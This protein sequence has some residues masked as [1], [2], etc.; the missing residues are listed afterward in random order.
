MDSL[1]FNL[2]LNLTRSHAT[3]HMTCERVSSRFPW[4]DCL[5]VYL[6]TVNNTVEVNSNG[7]GEN[8]TTVLLSVRVP[9][10]H[11]YQ[12]KEN[13]ILTSIVDTLSVV[14]G[15]SLPNKHICLLRHQLQV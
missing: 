5:S 11:G 7:Q 12:G 10:H 8:R 2:L 14:V 4:R 15:R 13:S 9:M 6:Q 1:A 3:G